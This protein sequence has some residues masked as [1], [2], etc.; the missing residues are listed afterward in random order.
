M[1]DYL[2]DTDAPLE[3]RKPPMRQHPG[4]RL[5]IGR[6]AASQLFVSSITL[7]EIRFG[8]EMVAETEKRAGLIHWLDSV[9]KPAFAGRIKQPDET[10]W[11]LMIKTMKAVN[12]LRQTY[13]MP[14]LAIAALAR[15]HSMTVVTRDTTPFERAG[16]PVL[17]PFG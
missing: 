2:P 17:N 7:A 14:D 13:Q 11:F 8:I 16:V 5:A 9:V 3:M 1:I 6:L 4:F 15:Q 10:T 12:A